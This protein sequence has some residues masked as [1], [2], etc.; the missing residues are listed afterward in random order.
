MEAVHAPTRNAGADDASLLGQLDSRRG[1]A[2]LARAVEAGV[3]KPSVQ[4]LLLEVG[5]VARGLEPVE[6]REARLECLVI[7]LGDDPIPES[8]PWIASHKA[9]IQARSSSCAATLSAVNLLDTMIL[10]S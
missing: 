9:M 8:P 2:L 6:E 4:L 7:D 1:L 3:R 5:R 10:L